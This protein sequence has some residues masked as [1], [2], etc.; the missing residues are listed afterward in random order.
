MS[1][2]KRHWNAKRLTVQA[3]GSMRRERL[4]FGAAKR[5]THM[6]GFLAELKEVGLPVS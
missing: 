1:W 4:A 3:S 5:R 6:L 2:S